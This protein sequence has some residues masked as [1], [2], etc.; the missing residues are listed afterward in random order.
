[1]GRDERGSVTAEVAVVTPAVVLIVLFAVSALS[2]GGQQIRLEHAAAQSARYLARG[3]DPAHVSD[4]AR[5]IAGDVN[6]DA[7]DDGDLACVTLTAAPP[8]PFPLLSARSC[9]L[10][11]GR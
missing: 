8:P 9:A 3:E 5:R 11:G 7:G 1:M 6:I 2:A 10:S 4:V